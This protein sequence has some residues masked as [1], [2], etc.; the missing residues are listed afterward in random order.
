MYQ[1]TIVAGPGRGRSFAL[2]EGE[3]V[4]GRQG[5]NAVVL[6]SGRVS[7]RH[8]VVLLV[9]GRLLVRDEGSINGTFV[10]GTMTKE[11]ELRAGDR[12]SVGEFVLQVA[13]AS[14]RVRGPISPEAGG[15]VIPLP[16][17]D[18]FGS[19]GLP[20][21]M[22][23]GSSALA[24][25]LPS[26]GPALGA[27]ASADPLSAGEVMPQDPAGKTRWLFE[28]RVMPL[29]YRALR[30]SEWRSVA[31]GTVGGAV[32]IGLLLVLQPVLDSGRGALL[33][34]VGRRARFMAQQIADQNAALVQ[35]GAVSQAR[36]GSYSSELAVNVAA[37]LAIEDNRVLASS[38]EIPGGYLTQGIEGRL[39]VVVSQ[40]V[41]DGKHSGPYVR[42]LERDIVV[43]AVPVE[44]YD[45]RLARNVPRALALVSINGALY[46]RGSGEIG[47]VYGQGLVVMGLLVGLALLAVYRLTLKP[48]EV[49][50]DDMDRVL[51]GDQREVTREFQW[52][53]L[54]PIFELVN[55]TLQR[56]PKGGGDDANFGGEPNP[57]AT[58][59]EALSAFRMLGD[60]VTAGIV[61]CDA[62]RRVLYINPSFE[63][64]SGIRTDQAAGQELASA[65]RDQAFGALATD[66]FSRAQPG[67]M[68]AAEDFDF[69][70]IPFRMQVAAFGAPGGEPKAY[71][72]IAARRES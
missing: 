39:A 18:P 57:A 9:A 31:A 42:A 40:A 61:L 70:G 50:S 12:I 64:T 2:R 48:F 30:K 13:R 54:D 8:C 37:L 28:R 43:A 63:E 20:A 32:A 41:R 10:N 49:L 45:P 56:V 46:T 29:F 59:E 17:A 71:L 51:K 36:V 6:P 7:K 16:G 68:P 38:I 33:N 53:E 55:S 4:V 27:V 65:A 25:P 23:A 72:M 62:E 14:A 22:T 35:S 60:A 1:L 24:V 19:S 47:V 34:E 58:A 5:G 11:R 44:V 26:S 21:P 52:S 69:G 67:G 3:N 66:L 15:Q